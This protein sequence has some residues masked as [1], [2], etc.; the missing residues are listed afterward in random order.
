MNG[1]ITYRKCNQKNNYFLRWMAFLVGFI[2]I[3]LSAYAQEVDEIE[4]VDDNPT[5]ASSVQ[6]RVEFTGGTPPYGPI[7]IDDFSLTST[8]GGN[9]VSVSSGSASPTVDVTVNGISGNGTIRLDLNDIDNSITDNGLNPLVSNTYTSGESYTIDNTDPSFISVSDA[10]DGTYRAGEA[11]TFDVN[12]GEAGL[13]VTADLSVLDSDFSNTQALADDG[14]GTYSYTTAALDAGGNMQEG[15]SIGINFSAEDAAGNA[16]SDN[17]LNLLLDKQIPT[18]SSTVN[19]AADNAYI[20]INFNEGVFRNGGGTNPLITSRLQL[21]FAQNGGNATNVTISNVKQTDSPVEAS[22]SNLGGGE[23]TI[24]VFFNVTGIPDGN[25]TIEI[26]PEDGTAIFDVAGNPVAA[27]GTT[28]SVALNNQC[29]VIADAGNSTT[30][31]DGESVNIGG[32]NTGTGG[33]GFYN[34]E[35][36]IPADG[37]AIISTTANPIV[38]PNTSTTYEVTVI[39][40]NGCTD[41]DQVTITVNALPAVAFNPDSIIFRNDATSFRLDDNSQLVPAHTTGMRGVLSGN[42]IT[43]NSSQDY[44]YFDP[45][46]ATDGDNVITY[47]YKDSNGCEATDAQTLTVVSPSAAVLNLLTQYCPEYNGGTVNGLQAAPGSVSAGRTFESLRLYKN[48]T[49]YISGPLTDGNSDDIYDLDLDALGA[50]EFSLAVFSTFN[51]GIPAGAYL[52]NFSTSVLYEKGDEPI[53]STLEESYCSNASPVTLTGSIPSYSNHVF[54]ASEGVSGNQ[55]DPGTVSFGP[56]QYQKIIT[57]MY[58]YEDDNGCDGSITQDVT[59]YR[60]PDAPTTTGLVE[61]CTEDVLNSLTASGVSGALFKWYKAADTGNPA[62]FIDNGTTLDPVDTDGMPVDSSMAGAYQYWVT[63]TLNGCESPASQ[64]TLEVHQ[65][66]APHISGLSPNYCVEA[67]PVIFSVSDNNGLPL[68]SDTLKINGEEVAN[69][70]FDPPALGVGIHTVTY[71]YINNNGCVDSTELEV[72]VHPLQ[73]VDFSGFNVSRTYCYS[74]EPITLVGAPAVTPGTTGTFSSNTGGLL[75]NDGTGLVT[76]SPR[77]AAIAA[78]ADSLGPVTTHEITYT[79][80]DANGCTNFKT[81]TITVYP[82]PAANY[83][84]LNADKAYC[85]DAESVT[86]TGNPKNSNGYFTGNGIADNADGTASFSPDIAAALAGASSPTDVQTQHAITYTYTNALGCVNEITDTVTVNPLPEVSFSGYNAIKTYCYNDTAVALSGTPLGSTGVFTGSGITDNENGTATF[87]PQVAAIDSGAV[88]AT[89]FRTDHGITYTYTDANGCVNNNEQTLSVNPLPELNFANLEDAY[90]VNREAFML[91]AIPAGGTFAGPG[92]TG[93]TFNPEDAGIGNHTITYTYTQNN[94]SCTNTISQNVTVRPLPEPD[95]SFTASCNDAIVSFTD[96]STISPLDTI[97]RITNYSWSFGDFSA[98]DTAQHPTHD[99]DK[100][101]TYDITFTPY[102]AFGCNSSKDTTL[103]IDAIPEADF[104]WLNACLGDTTSFTSISSVSLGNIDTY[105]WNFGDGAIVNVGEEVL[106]Q[107]NEIGVYE[108]SLRIV[109]DNGCTDTISKEIYILPKV[110]SYPYIQDFETTTHGWIVEGANA[111]WQQGKPAGITIN[112]AASGE[113][114]LMT[115][116]DSTYPTNE[117]SWVNTPCFDISSLENPVLSLKTWYATDVDFDGAVI[118]ASVDD[119]QNW[120]VLGSLEEGIAWYN[121]NSIVGNPGGQSSSA[122][123][124]TGTSTGWQNAKFSLDQFT[125][126]TCIRFRVAFA[127]NADNT[128]GKIFDGFAFDDFRIGERNRSILLE[129]FTNISSTEFARIDAELQQFAKDHGDEVITLQYH[130]DFPGD[131]PLNEHNRADPSARALYY[132]IARGPRIIMDGNYI[133]EEFTQWAEADFQERILDDAPFTLSVNFNNA[134]ESRFNINATVKAL[135]AIQAE[136]TLHIAVVEQEIETSLNGL[137]ERKYFNVLKKMLPDAGGTPLIKNQ[138]EAEESVEVSQAWGGKNVFD[139]GQLAVVV[140][141]Q[142]N[143]TK[144]IYQAT[145]AKPDTPPQLVTGL[146]EPTNEINEKGF[147]IYPNPSSEKVQVLMGKSSLFHWKIY[148]KFG[149]L[150]KTGETD[151]TNT[152]SLN[153]QNLSNGLYILQLE[154]KDK[155]I[156][157]T[158]FSVIR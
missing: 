42:G 65:R 75:N 132:G 143:I 146:D 148:D 66:S 51:S 157:S 128:P 156:Y 87:T 63:Q 141:L 91:K 76:F 46:L 82:L 25:E 85:Y 97:D 10:G 64:T 31:C 155:Q 54:S 36:R 120:E 138:W 50:G 29:T 133:D 40:D 93:E 95:F 59:V 69:P 94:T 158:R 53:I 16:S 13:T 26:I 32:N 47:T 78:G 81:H 121:S 55:F 12:L 134:T 145:F 35:W 33:S 37:P 62:N 126:V 79:F 153:V 118:Q 86:L 56:A 98:A 123:G 48:G 7:A 127:S 154:N 28:G 117:N 17:S 140:F 151:Y 38:A 149:R 106:H 6:F 113:Q 114:V 135:T 30:I 22:A 61:Y 100:S 4:R 27:A 60:V 104:S 101:G 122:L 139:A 103:Y 34:Y 130:T 73:L 52:D 142:D 83:T 5:N 115:N 89:D 45:A 14:D 80:T 71:I 108:A 49:G 131:D 19:L 144:E 102:T 20:D 147:T 3:C 68:G 137:G 1:I 39:D 116:L 43:Y 125:E 44:Y 84:G 15:T 24:R 99:Y 112:I 129:H 90:C 67:D 152:F 8:V 105:E 107:Y 74:N 124:W 150:I 72:E 119:G 77:L 23:S 11:I 109:T 136:V 92:V 96:A 9:I 70:E 57:I 41:T 18:L 110:A 58:N 2:C 88:N 21:V 111:S